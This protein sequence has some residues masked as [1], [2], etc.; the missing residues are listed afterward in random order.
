[1]DKLSDKQRKVFKLVK[2]EG[3]SAKEVA[4]EMQMSVSAVK[5]SVHRSTA[6]LKEVLSEH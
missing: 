4:E 6:K 5:V 2:I 3:Y 1:M